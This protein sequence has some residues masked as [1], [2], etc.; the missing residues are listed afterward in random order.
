MEDETT[1]PPDSGCGAWA[2]VGTPFAE[3]PVEIMG[4]AKALAALGE[5]AARRIAWV[6]CDNAVELTLRDLVTIAYDRKLTRNKPSRTFT[7]L[8]MQAAE[9]IP[10]IVEFD[11]S[12]FRRHH[13]TRNKLYHE[14]PDLSPSPDR[15]LAFI[16]QTD[17]L[18]QVVFGGRSESRVDQPFLRAADPQWCGLASDYS[19]AADRLHVRAAEHPD[20]PFGV[21][22]PADVWELLADIPIRVSDRLADL[23]LDEEAQNWLSGHFIDLQVD[24]PTTVPEALYWLEEAAR[25]FGLLDS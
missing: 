22:V 10:D 18:L 15:L 5:E 4:F 13:A 11:P 19:E 12:V 24:E 17:R 25:I 7:E 23:P 14:S 6:L 20:T 9:I 21:V 3:G 2:P 1:E 8:A 16:S